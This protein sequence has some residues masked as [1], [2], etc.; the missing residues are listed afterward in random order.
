MRCCAAVRQGTKPASRSTFRCLDVVGWLTESA[1]TSSP[2][3][4]SDD[5]SRSRIRRRVGSASTVNESSDTSQ[6]ASTC[7]CLSRP[8]QEP[9]G[10]RLLR[11]GGQQGGESLGDHPP[12]HPAA[13][14]L[15]RE[16]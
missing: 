10:A 12:H 15:P 8:I 7:I 16:Q 13:A 4:L 3:L 9:Q 1:S 5:R 14:L 11:E 2:T 6:Y